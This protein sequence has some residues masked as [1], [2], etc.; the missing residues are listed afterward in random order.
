M[1]DTSNKRQITVN[2]TKVRCPQPGTEVWNS[3]PITFLTIPPTGSVTCPYCETV[4][5]Y[6]EDNKNDNA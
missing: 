4:Y 3:H 5:T 6:V 2:V 1:N